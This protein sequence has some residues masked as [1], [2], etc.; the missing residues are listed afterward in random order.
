VQLAR[1]LENIIDGVDEQTGEVPV[2]AGLTHALASVARGTALALEDLSQLDSS[3]AGE[4]VI[5]HINQALTAVAEDMLSLNQAPAPVGDNATLPGDALSDALLT[6]TRE[7]TAQ[8]DN[9]LLAP[10]DGLRDVLA[11][12]TGALADLLEAL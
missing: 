8:L 9:R 7:T 10:L 11:P 4:A 2:I 3:G 1:N 5:G 6:V 12:V